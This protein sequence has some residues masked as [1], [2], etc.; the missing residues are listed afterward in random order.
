MTY[1]FFD[2]K[3]RSGVSLNEQLAE[4]LHKSVIKNPKKE[5]S[6]RLLKRIFG[7]QI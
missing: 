2:N 6:M 5:K 7:Q 1:I 4:E 3:I